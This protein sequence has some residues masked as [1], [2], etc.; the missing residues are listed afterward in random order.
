MALNRDFY[1]EIYE[2]EDKW[3][4]YINNNLLN[5]V[6]IKYTLKPFYERKKEEIEKDYNISGNEILGQILSIITNILNQINNLNEHYRNL[7]FVDT[8][9][10][11]PLFLTNQLSNTNQNDEKNRRII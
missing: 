6:Y 3:I 2:N 8:T 4:Y 9:T 5:T 10:L 1:N 11:L 7:K